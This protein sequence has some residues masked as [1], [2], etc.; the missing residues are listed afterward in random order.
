VATQDVQDLA[1]NHLADFHSAFSTAVA[2][3]TVH[4]FIASQRPG[5]ERRM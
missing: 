2:V 3:D 1:G 4:P 5:W